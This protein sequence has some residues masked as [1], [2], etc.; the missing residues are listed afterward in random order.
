MQAKTC[1]FHL[2]RDGVDVVGLP[3]ILIDIKPTSQPVSAE[4]WLGEDRLQEDAKGSSEIGE[5]VYKLPAV[6]GKQVSIQFANSC[7]FV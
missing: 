1:E 3:P 4:L 5:S 2:A 7:S 6:A